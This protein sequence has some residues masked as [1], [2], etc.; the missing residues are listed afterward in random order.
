[1]EKRVKFI[2]SAVFAGLVLIIC[3]ILYFSY[4]FISPLILPSPAC[5]N[6]I[7]EGGEEGGCFSDCFYNIEINISNSKKINPLIFGS[8]LRDIEYGR[9]VWDNNTDSFRQYAVD[10]IK[11]LNVQIKIR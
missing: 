8:N 5:G 2:Y 9:W 10:A 7:C 11:E 4:I 6:G 1:M 3:S